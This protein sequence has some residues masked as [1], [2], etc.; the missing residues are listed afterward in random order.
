MLSSGTVPKCKLHTAVFKQIVTCSATLLQQ[1]FSANEQC[2]ALT[3]FQHK[4]KVSNGM[5]DVSCKMHA[6]ADM[7]TVVGLLATACLARW[8]VMYSQSNIYLKLKG[9]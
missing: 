7:M 9:G 6:G 8:L 4:R 2:F 1:Y 3:T 5:G